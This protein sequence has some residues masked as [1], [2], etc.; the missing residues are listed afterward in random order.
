MVV[1]AES[2]GHTIATASISEKKRG[3]GRPRS[4]NADTAILD[5]TLELLAMHGLSGLSVE[6]V[7]ARAGVGKTTI[8]RRWRSRDEMVAAAFRFVSDDV[9]IPD[10]GNVRDDLVR[11]LGHYQRRSLRSLPATL[12]PRLLALTIT[13]DELLQIF[14]D[15]SFA[16]RKAAVLSVLKRGK[17]RGE[18]RPDTDI[19]LA[20]MML[21]GPMFHLVL[22]NDTT[23]F[24]DTTLPGRLVDTLVGG[25]MR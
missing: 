10:T 9:E 6:A 15:H 2:A 18:L 20:F 21:S 25:L 8:Y 16:P 14:L 11:L 17:D 4:A 22:T 19:E 12:M 7:A 1:A 5:A 23:A 3:P 24:A 13:N